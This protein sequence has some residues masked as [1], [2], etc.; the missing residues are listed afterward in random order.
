MDHGC[1]WPDALASRVTA[2][3]PTAT[4][5]RERAKDGMINRLLGIEKHKG[6]RIASQRSLRA[7]RSQKSSQKDFAG[8]QEA[9]T[10]NR[11]S[12]TVRPLSR[13]QTSKT[14]SAAQR[15]F[16]RAGWAESKALKEQRITR[17]GFLNKY[18]E[19][20]QP[21]SAAERTKPPNSTRRRPRS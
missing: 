5:P 14:G 1:R 21:R 15:S 19:H 7:R 2:A 8:N 10:P 12:H 16:G 3:R 11:F 18:F 17:A 6:C 13:S 4:S 9:P 20:R